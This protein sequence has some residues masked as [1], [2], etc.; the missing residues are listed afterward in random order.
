MSTAARTT[1][2]DLRVDAHRKS[3]ILRAAE[4]LGMN[5]T[6]FI[7]ERVFPDAERIVA[8]NNRTRLSKEDWEKFCARL[9]E[10]P[11]DLPEL[12]RLMREP[13]IFVKG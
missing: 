11:R 12:R 9:D 3:V 13:S 2:I 7:M 6:Q 1:R 10:P 4:M 8:E 5:I